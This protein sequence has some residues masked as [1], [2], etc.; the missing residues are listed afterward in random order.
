MSYSLTKRQA[1]VYEYIRICLSEKRYSPTL[2][3]IADRFGFKTHSTS[4]FFV[5]TLIGKKWI[6]RKKN[7]QIELGY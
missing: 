6:S 4:Q 2:Q 1:K 5:N 3:E 7:R